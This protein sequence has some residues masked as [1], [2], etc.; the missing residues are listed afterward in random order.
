MNT[1]PISSVVVWA[2]AALLWAPALQ[3]DWSFVMMGD[4]KGEGGHTTT[5]VSEELPIIAQ[6]IASLTLKPDLVLVAG[7]LCCGDE[8]APGSPLWNYS[9]QFLNWKLAMQPVFD[10]ATNT[11]IP[12]YPVRGNHD[13]AQS[14]DAPIPDLK[15]AYYTAFSPYVPD[16]GPNTVSSGNQVG[17]SY[18]FTHNNATFVAADQ[19]FYYN[20]TPGMNG[21]HDLDRAWVTQQFQESSSPYKILMAHEPFF[22]TVGYK[23]EEHFF[24]DNAAGF[25]TRSNF[26]NALGANGVEL[27]VTGHIHN[28]SVAST[29]NDYGDTIIQLMAGGG[30]ASLVPVIDKHDPGVD[31]LHT[32]DLFG[33]ALATVSDAAMTIQYYSLHTND[34]SWTVA[35]YVTTISPNQMVPEPSAAVLLGPAVVAL[36]TGRSRRRRRH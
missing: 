2:A 10:Y 8:L 22:M 18:S 29:T 4:T 14:Q 17:F 16:N 12:I 30:G 21:Y 34:N 23:D 35:S 7:D 9:I 31:V 6:K 15:E 33:F 20:Q 26:W 11:G 1:K 28:E 32:N 3:A 13:N 5:G 24:G 19:Y 36:M 27:Y 25:S